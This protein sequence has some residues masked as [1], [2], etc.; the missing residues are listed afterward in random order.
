MKKTLFNGFK[1]VCVSAMA[2]AAVSCYDDSA[3]QEKLNSLDARLTQVEQNLNTEVDNLEALIAAKVAV[4]D[5]TKAYG[6]VV[7]TL[8]DGSKVELSQPA[9]NASSLVTIVEED[10]VQYWAVVGVEAHTGVPVGDPDYDINF[11]INPET[12]V[13]E[14]NVNGED[15]VSTGV[16]ADAQD[17][18]IVTEFVDGEDYVG[19]V[20]DGTMITLE[21]YVADAA[22]LGLTRADFFLR[23]EGAKTLPIVAE[24]VADCYVMT[25]PN[26]W[27]AN[28][29]GDNL[30]VKAPTKAAIEIGAAE[31]EGVIV[32]HA[33]TEDGKCKT[34][35]VSVK[36]GLGLTLSVD[37]AGNLVVKNA[38]AGEKVS[39]WGDVSFGF[40]DFVFGLATPDD[41][42]ADPK[43]Y[44]EFYNTN[45]SAPNYEDP[46]FPSMYNVVMGGEYVEG[47][48]EV[49]VINTTVAEMYAALYYREPAPGASFVV[50]AAPVV[51]GS[52]GA[53]DYEN[54]VYADYVCSVW[55]VEA[56]EVTHSDI[57][58]TANVAGASKYVIGCVAESYYNNEYNPMTFE[59]YMNAPMGGPWSG[60][61]KYGAA[62]AL[63]TLLPAE[64]VPAE[65]NLSDLLGEKLSAGE[66]YKIWVMP[67]FDHL[68]KLDEANSYPEADYYVYD[69][70]A[71]KF[72]EHF[73]PFV[74]DVK[75]N[76][77][78]AGGAHAAE[79]T[80]NRNDYTSIYVDVTPSEGTESVYYCWY[81]EADYNMFESDAAIMA[82]LFE[83]CYSPFTS[84]EQASKTY[85]NPG[86]TY[87][88]ATLSI[89]TDGKYGEIVAKTFSTRALPKTSDVT[90]TL[91]GEPKLEVTE[92]NTDG[93][94]K[95]GTYTV[96]VNVVGA[97]KVMGYNVTHTD[98]NFATFFNNVAA[99][100]HMS[101]YYGYQMVDVVDGKATLTFAYNSYKKDYYVAAY[102]VTDGVVSAL[103]AEPLNIHLFD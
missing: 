68:A 8:A 39:M 4:V 85:V 69:Y 1:A 65:F 71:F 25:K 20:V 64:E 17:A 16:V 19:I 31:S 52:E 103:S 23:Y 13:L 24:G 55:D 9:K 27:S 60:F 96:T 5:V 57:T 43:A 82:D 91:D 101:T 7:L 30:V 49:D 74:L 46:I 76:D 26:G 73:L 75:T 66:N 62:E 81:K 6:K 11:Q 61:V 34:A 35:K 88:L 100:G 79:L 44:L 10:G 94:V 77:L 89:G 33:T 70:S 58:L 56:T 12:K 54:L 32:L 102:N 90:V 92:T 41:F 51:P 53:A 63:G 21:K 83:N 59:E 29:D 67:I 40:E 86:E 80:F 42:Y 3:V 2:L 84:K 45:W 99:N 15:W 37:V 72:D 47:E 18:A 48:Y 98:S 22:N 93:T 28:V 38:Y 50:W 87:V 36:A 78:Q 95:S 14:Y 97:T